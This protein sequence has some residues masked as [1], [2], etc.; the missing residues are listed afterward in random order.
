MRR[1]RPRAGGS[2]PAPRRRRDPCRPHVL[3]SSWFQD[4]ESVDLTVAAPAFVDIT[5]IGLEALPGLGEERFAG[6][7]LRSPGGG[8][9]I[10]IG[11]ARLGLRTALAAPL[12]ADLDGEYVRRELARDSIEVATL[13]TARTPTTVVMPW[14]GERAMV[15]YDPGIVATAA[16]IAA[17]APRA[18]VAGFGQLDRVPPGAVKYATCG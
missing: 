3:R 17:A 8:A 4:D 12:G 15:T 16:D 7:L 2:T 1:T 6:Q 18:V 9:I 14:D 13:A 10:A 5:F 11:A